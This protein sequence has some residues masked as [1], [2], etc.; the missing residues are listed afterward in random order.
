MT[1]SSCCVTSSAA[2]ADAA[3]QAAARCRRDER[4]RQPNNGDATSRNHILSCALMLTLY[5]GRQHSWNAQRRA[6][7]SVCAG[8]INSHS[9]TVRAT[10]D[11]QLVFCASPRRWITF[12]VSSGGPRR[13]QSGRLI[14]GQANSNSP[15]VRTAASPKLQVCRLAL[16]HVDRTRKDVRRRKTRVAA[17]WWLGGAMAFSYS[18]LLNAVGRR[19]SWQ[20]MAA[21]DAA[22]QL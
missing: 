22:D 21:R 12:L 10:S 13:Q 6:C 17:A 15:G 20:R 19:H 9:T 7:P 18:P 8:G 5:Y 3:Q 1:R 2:V 4:R 16:T 11:A 14:L